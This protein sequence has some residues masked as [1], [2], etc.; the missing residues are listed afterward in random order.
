MYIYACDIIKEKVNIS[1]ESNA[2]GYWTRKSVQAH[3]QYTQVSI[4]DI[5]TILQVAPLSLATTIGSPHLNSSPSPRF[6]I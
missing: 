4:K 3:I 2:N 5:T 1:K 6:H